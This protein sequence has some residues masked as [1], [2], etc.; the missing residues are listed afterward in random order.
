MLVLQ[1]HKVTKNLSKPL[2]LF[3]DIWL[4]QS[5]KRKII[6]TKTLPVCNF[7]CIFAQFLIK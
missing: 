2:H 4:M 6:C 7:Y 1:W 3:F 5:G